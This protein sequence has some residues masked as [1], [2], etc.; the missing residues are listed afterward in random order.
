MR[1]PAYHIAEP[2]R[3]AH[4]MDVDMDVDMDVGVGADV[5]MDVDV[6]CGMLLCWACGS[7]KNVEGNKGNV[8]IL[9]LFV[10]R[11]VRIGLEHEKLQPHDDALDGQHRL[12][13]LSQD[14]QAHMPLHVNVRVEHGGF[15]QNFR[16]VM[17]VRRGDLEI[18]HKTATPVDAL[19]WHD[20]HLEVHQVVLA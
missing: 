1:A 9:H 18:E 8:G 19:V 10:E 16:C 5:D 20:G 4:A 14:I 11:I 15:A 12:P 7:R 17:R 3:G 6:A 2:I 13:I